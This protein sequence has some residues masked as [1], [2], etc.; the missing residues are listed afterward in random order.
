MSKVSCFLT[1]IVHKVRQKSIPYEILLQFSQQWL[2]IS[3]RNF[4]NVFSHPM[5]TQWY[6]RQSISLLCF[7]VINIT[8]MPHIDFSV[9]KNVRRKNAFLKSHAEVDVKQLSGFH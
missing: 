6:Y 9:L 7:K 8:A 5:C 2:G 4:T 3:K 1:H